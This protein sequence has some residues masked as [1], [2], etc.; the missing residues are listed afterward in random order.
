MSTPKMPKPPPPPPPAPPP[1]EKPPEALEDAVDST[2]ASLK[3]NKAGSKK[4][5]GRGNKSGV[6]VA[7]YKAKPKK[8][9]LSIAS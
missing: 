9:G 8:S 3:K 7:N 4:S 1:P 6:Q 5:L 2:A